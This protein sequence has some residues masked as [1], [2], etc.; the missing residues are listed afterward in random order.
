M[1]IEDF[2]HKHED[3]QPCKQFNGLELCLLFIGYSFHKS[4]RWLVASD[5]FQDLDQ[6]TQNRKMKLTVQIILAAIH[7]FSLCSSKGNWNSFDLKLV[8]FMLAQMF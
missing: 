8:L 4:I 5:H 2:I 3:V 1:T 7:F 6:A